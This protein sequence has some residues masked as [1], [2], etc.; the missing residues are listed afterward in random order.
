MTKLLEMREFL[1]HNYMR[2]EKI[3]IPTGR[4]IFYFTVLWMING[5]FNLAPTIVRGMIYTLLAVLSIF[6]PASW[7]ILILIAVI[8]AHLMAISIEAAA[9]LTFIM[10]IIYILFIRLFPKM[11]WLS[12]AVP[13]L[14]AFKLGYVLPILAGIFF[15]PS[16]ILSICTGALV[17]KFSIYIPGLLA[18]KSESLYDMPVT[19]MSMYRY[20][21]NTILQDTS[22]LLTIMIFALVVAITYFVS[23][24]TFDHIWYIAI[25]VGGAVNILGFIIGT[26]VLKSDISITGILVGTLIACAVCSI[27][28]F[29]RFSLDYSRAEK[30]QF[31]DEEYYYFVK[32]VPKISISKT[33]KDIKKIK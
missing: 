1:I 27:A 31:E 14:F 23:R 30:V 6:I 11:A 28:Q 20:C 16:A 7:F 3:I 2:F 32:V 26:I 24:F 9:L 18:V 29:L 12:I 5:Y 17:Y 13:F 4:F 8:A 25:V 21:A 10:I 22:I 33:E 15:G 19:L